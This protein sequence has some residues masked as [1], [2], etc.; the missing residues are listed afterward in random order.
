MADEQFVPDGAV[1]KLVARFPGILAFY[2]NSSAWR[3]IDDLCGWAAPAN[4][5]GFFQSGSVESYS[6]K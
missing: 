6:S 5:L 1:Y 2:Q 4:A 3:R